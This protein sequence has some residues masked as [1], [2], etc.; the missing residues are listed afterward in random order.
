M[1]LEALRVVLAAARLLAVHAQ[2]HRKL[3]VQDFLDHAVFVHHGVPFRPAGLL[4]GRQALPQLRV[5]YPGMDKRRVVE[6]KVAWRIRKPLPP[7]F[8]DQEPGN[9]LHDLGLG[10]LLFEMQLDHLPIEQYANA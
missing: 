5:G 6:Q 4:D 2:E 8:I 7:K 9:R 3:D 1:E 10:V